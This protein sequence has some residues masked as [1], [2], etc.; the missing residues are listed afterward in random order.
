MRTLWLA[1]A[2]AA[3]VGCVS[4]CGAPSIEGVQEVRAE[5]PRAPAGTD[6]QLRA[7]VAGDREF[8]LGLYH[9]LSSIEDGNFFYSPY[10]IASA[11]SMA[12]AGARANTAAQ[13]DTVLGAGDDPAAWHAG[14][15]GLDLALAAARP[16]PFGRPP[17]KL[18]ATN[19]IFGQSGYDFEAE[20]LRVLAANYGAGL[21]TVD[22]RTAPEQARGR[23]NAWVNARTNGRIRELLGTLDPLTRLVLVNAI[24]FKAEWVNE[25]DANRTGDRPFNLIE[26]GSVDVSMMSAE[27]DARYAAGDG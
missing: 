7:V 15:N 23:I 26:G 19:G 5:A 25:F 3:V 9:Q 6:D 21:Q 16:V 1:V 13:L 12:Y 14:R 17:L 8:A 18:E 22:Y 24:Y 4:A 10:S 2:L 11:L 20:F 27:L